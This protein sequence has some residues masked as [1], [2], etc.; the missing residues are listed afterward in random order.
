M[1]P[2]VASVVTGATNVEQLKELLDIAEKPQL[3]ESILTAIDAIHQ[4]CP[5]PCP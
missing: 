1:H 4:Q 3:D 2:L 5:S